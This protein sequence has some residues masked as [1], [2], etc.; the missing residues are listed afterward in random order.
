MVRPAKSARRR[1]FG[2][3][4]IHKPRRGHILNAS[5]C[6]K[7]HGAG[8]MSCDKQIAAPVEGH[9]RTVISRCASYAV[10]PNITSVC[11]TVF[12][13]ENIAEPERRDVLC[14]P[15]RVEVN[16]TCVV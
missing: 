16:S 2:N 7:I 13:K 10:C 14:R 6:I 1:I 12:C 15:S 5:A 4:N 9:G 8:K 3:K 11:C